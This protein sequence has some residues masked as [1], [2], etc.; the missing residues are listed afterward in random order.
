P[1]GGRLVR[2]AAGQTEDVVER[3]VVGGE[4][5]EAGASERRAQ[6]GGVDGDD[7]AEASRRIVEEH[8]LLVLVVE[9]VEDR[10]LA[11]CHRL[12]R[13]LSYHSASLRMIGSMAR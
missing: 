9:R 5:I 6:G 13:R 2:H 10:H 1:G 8:D 7:C 12:R 4:G 3:L 11:G